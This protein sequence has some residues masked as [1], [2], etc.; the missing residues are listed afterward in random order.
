MMFR[1]KQIAAH[2]LKAGSIHAF[3]TAMWFSLAFHISLLQFIL[4]KLTFKFPLNF[5]GHSSFFKR[6]RQCLRTCRKLL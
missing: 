4:G 6:D 3:G 5:F 2:L 1:K